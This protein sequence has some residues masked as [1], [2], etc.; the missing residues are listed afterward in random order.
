MENS[1]LQK[2]KIQDIILDK[3]AAIMQ[4]QF[5]YLLNQP[6]H[7]S[8][9]KVNKYAN[10][11]KYVPIDKVEYL[12]DTLFQEWKIEILE[13]KQIFSAVQVSIR[14]HYKNPANGIWMFHDGVGA[15]ELQTASGSGVLKPD[16]SNI[17]KGAVEMAVPKAKSEAIKDASHHLGKLFGR[18]VNRDGAIDYK[19]VH[20]PQNTERVRLQKFISQAG[21]LEELEDIEI[22]I[23]RDD[24]EMVVLFDA[25]KKELVTKLQNQ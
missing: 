19:M 1:K 15:C 11:S 5:K 16:F 6:P 23:S 24:K 7:A 9:L 14:L 22:H 10:N 4:D 21:N 25:K 13:T 3:E 12:L 18:D 20:Q 2:I 8:W 17:N